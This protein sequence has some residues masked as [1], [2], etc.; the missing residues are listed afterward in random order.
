MHRASAFFSWLLAQHPTDAEAFR[1][2]GLPTNTSR[3]YLLL[4]ACKHGAERI[5][6]RQ[7]HRRWRIHRKFEELER[8]GQIVRIGVDEMRPI[9][10]AEMDV[11]MERAGVVKTGTITFEMNFEPNPSHTFLDLMRLFYYQ[12]EPERWQRVLRRWQFKHTDPCFECDGKGEVLDAPGQVLDGGT[13]WDTCP[14]CKGSG[15]FRKPMVVDMIDVTN[16]IWYHPD[17]IIRGL[18]K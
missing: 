10:E 9:S 11:M 16:D 14:A 8:T 3:L 7:W 2:F 15:R 18:P 4:R 5:R 17:D 1:R 6:V 12:H 13:Y